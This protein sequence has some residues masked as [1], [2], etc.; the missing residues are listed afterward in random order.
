MLSRACASLRCSLLIVLINSFRACAN[1]TQ[2]ATSTILSPFV[3]AESGSP[4]DSGRAAR[5]YRRAFALF[6]AVVRMSR[7]HKRQPPSMHSQPL[8]SSAHNAAYAGNC[9]QKRQP[10]TQPVQPVSIRTCGKPVTS[11]KTRVA[12][13][14]SAFRYWRGLPVR[15]LAAWS[16]MLGVGFGPCRLCKSRRSEPVSPYFFFYL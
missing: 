10:Q 16:C 4:T 13:H 5:L 9:P 1:L 11:Q 14:N 7:S 6:L 8:S 2:L 15:L 3:S 12:C